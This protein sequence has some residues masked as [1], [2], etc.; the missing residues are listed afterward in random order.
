M[1]S[2]CWIRCLH[3]ENVSRSKMCL[4]ECWRWTADAIVREHGQQFGK[5]K[6]NI[7]ILIQNIGGKEEYLGLILIF[8]HLP[9]SLIFSYNF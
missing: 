9:Y 4:F 6:N 3:F 2:L 7:N 1:E 5:K 8:K